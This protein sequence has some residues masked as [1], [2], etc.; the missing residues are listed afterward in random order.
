MKCH[1]TDLAAS[2][3]DRVHFLV[4]KLLWFCRVIALRRGCP[5][6]AGPTVHKAASFSGWHPCR[7]G[8]QADGR[9]AFSNSAL[10]SLFRLPTRKFPLAK[11]VSLCRHSI[12][13]TFP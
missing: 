13:V 3:Q 9:L 1:V 2:L 11:P 7:S 12:G 4:G 5:R 8:G 10:A 6:S